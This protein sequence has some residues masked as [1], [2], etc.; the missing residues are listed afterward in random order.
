MSDRACGAPHCEHDVYA[1]GHCG[2]HYRQL[3]RHGQVQADPVPAACAVAGCDRAAVT[4]GW[5]HA[6]Y[7]RWARSRDLRADVP[8]GGPAACPCAVDGCERTAVGGRYCRPHLRRAQRHGDPLAGR[9]ERSRGAGG[10]LSHG[11]WK[12]PVP[13]ADRHLVP[14]GRTSELE[15]RLVMAR[16]LGR[17]LSPDEVVH[18]VNGDRIDNRP[19]NLELWITAQP[20][21]QRL[22]DKLAFA[23]DL[24]RRYDG[25]AAGALGLAL[26]PETGAPRNDS[27]PPAG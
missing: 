23:Y 21:G 5:C 15:H 27:S 16:L 2:R 3:L 1:R 26:D 20:K 12:V 13:E 25:E 8:L 19:E 24:L 4:R 18:H 22:E 17:P 7:L 11:Y 6:H 10:S 14:P 9:P